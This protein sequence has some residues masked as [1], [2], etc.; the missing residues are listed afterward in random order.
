[1][2]PMHVNPILRARRT[3][4]AFQLDNWIPQNV[5]VTHVPRGTM[6]QIA[7]HVRLWTPLDDANASTISLWTYHH[8]NMLLRIHCET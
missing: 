8:G 2:R 6:E 1:M 5:T 7:R 4:T 3:I